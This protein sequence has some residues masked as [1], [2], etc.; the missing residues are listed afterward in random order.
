MLTKK[1]SCPPHRSTINEITIRKQQKTSS[2]FP[3]SKSV[4]LFTT[5]FK[6]NSTP[7]KPRILTNCK[8]YQPCC[9]GSTR[10]FYRRF[11]LQK[12][13]SGSW[14]HFQGYPMLSRGENS[15]HKELQSNYTWQSMQASGSFLGRQTPQRNYFYGIGGEVG[16]F[17][18]QPSGSLHLTVRLTLHR[19]DLHALWMHTAFIFS[20]EK[21]VFYKN[22]SLEITV[23]KG[24]DHFI[25]Y[26]L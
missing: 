3:A 20:W 14:E 22:M 17:F 26:H 16:Y 25:S 23:T 13:C 12:S 8:A 7:G 19:G 6:D 24:K 11:Q 1:K 2:P 5:G 15:I 4:G 10:H 21:E 9:C 18:P